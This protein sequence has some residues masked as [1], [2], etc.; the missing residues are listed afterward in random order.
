MNSKR[1]LLYAVASGIIGTLLILGYLQNERNKMEAM[2]SAYENSAPSPG[3]VR[4]V[5]SARDIGANNR[6]T[7]SMLQYQEIDETYAPPNSIFNI[8]EIVGSFALREIEKGQQIFKDDVTRAGL[9]QGTGLSTVVADSNYR[10]LSLPVGGVSGLSGLIRPGDYVDIL[11]TFLN[12]PGGAGPLTTTLCQNVRVLAVGQC[13]SPKE[14]PYDYSSVT[15]AVLPQEAQSLTLA[16]NSGAKI[17][18][19]LRAKGDKKM[20]DSEQLQ[21]LS[22]NALLKIK[23]ELAE[24][25]KR[26]TEVIY[27]V[28]KEK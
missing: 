17:T 3:R 14:A 27:G 13:L 26:I 16:V 12:Y 1:V 22:F 25:R 6:I 24:Q 18:L 5:V 4:I 15:V 28:N 7:A 8:P 9:T 21:D 10:A 19:T 2:K 20:V 11:A 23:K